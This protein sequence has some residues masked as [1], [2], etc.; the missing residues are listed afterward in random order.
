MPSPAHILKLPE[1]E[2]LLSMGRY[3]ALLS[4]VYS[5]VIFM[6]PLAAGPKGRKRRRQHL[7]VQ[8]W[9]AWRRGSHPKQFVEQNKFRAR[10]IFIFIFI[11]NGRAKLCNCTSVS[12]SPK[13]RY[14]W[15]YVLRK[16][17]LAFMLG[18]RIPEAGVKKNC[19][20]NKCFKTG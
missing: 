7:I 12:C 8:E 15:L 18:K 17:K 6:D 1:Q 20:H 3:G 16:V 2:Q 9:G 19:F 5:F 14:T 11:L 13:L 10:L 4:V